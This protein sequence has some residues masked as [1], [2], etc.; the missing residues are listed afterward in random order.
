MVFNWFCLRTEI[1]QGC[2]SQSNIRIANFVT[3]MQSVIKKRNSILLVN[4]LIK[5]QWNYSPTFLIIF[6]PYS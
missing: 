2:L 6:H 1:E 4:V 5:V 3:K